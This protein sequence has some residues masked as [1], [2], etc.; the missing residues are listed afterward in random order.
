MPSRIYW[1]DETWPGKLALAARPRGGD[2]LSDE[3]ADWK[4]AGIDSVLSLLEP[5]EEKDLDLGS[6]G[7]EVQ[8]RGLDFLSLPIPDRGVPKSETKLGE[9]LETVNRTL[10]KG[11][12]VLVHCRQGVGRSSL[13]AACLLIRK[14]M[15]PGEALENI[16]SARGVVVPETDQQRDW[17]DHYA[18]VF[19]K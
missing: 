13:V 15:S 14:G 11:K 5:D 10:A 17:I 7:E 8:T 18:A 1:L 3:V 9:M 12:N 2:W 19:A 4:R 6:E 16:S